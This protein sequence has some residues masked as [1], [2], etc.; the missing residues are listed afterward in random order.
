MLKDII[1]LNDTTVPPLDLMFV[2][3]MAGNTD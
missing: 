1:L 3:L 2:L